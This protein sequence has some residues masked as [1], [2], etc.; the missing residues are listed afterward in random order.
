SSHPRRDRPTRPGRGY[1]PARP[2]P[3]STG[4]ERVP[5]PGPS[6]PAP[7]S[8]GPPGTHALL[9]HTPRGPYPKRTPGAEKTYLPDAASGRPVSRDRTDHHLATSNRF[10]RRG[11][12]SQ[13][14][15]RHG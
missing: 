11:T 12:P 10:L 14:R 13:G 4:H 8:L 15:G 6:G 1:R 2:L 3:T 7:P 9:R 5:T